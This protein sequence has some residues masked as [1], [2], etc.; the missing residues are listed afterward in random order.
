GTIAKVEFFNGVNKLG[1]DTMGE[2]SYAWTNVPA[3][4]YT[5]TAKATDD[6][7]AMTTS[8]NIVVVVRNPLTSLALQN[9]AVVGPNF[10]FSFQTQ[11]N[12]NYSVQFAT[13][14]PA[15]NWQTLPTLVGDGSEAVIDHAISGATNRFYRVIAD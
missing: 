5:L 9:V 15:A 12:W 7:G 8:G 4:T 11:S 13:S 1:E 2:Y 14:L 10:H 3:G 6:A